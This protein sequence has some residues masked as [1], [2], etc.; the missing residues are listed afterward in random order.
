MM[1]NSNIFYHPESINETNLILQI[2]TLS[3]QSVWNNYTSKD[4]RGNIVG[5]L[6]DD[7]SVEK[8]SFTNF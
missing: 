3:F 4:I 7:S 8:T 1:Q 2:I 5:D 6:T